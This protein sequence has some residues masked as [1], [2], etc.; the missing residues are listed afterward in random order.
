MIDSQGQIWVYFLDIPLVEE[1][2]TVSDYFPV[3]IGFGVICQNSLKKMY[4]DFPPHICWTIVDDKEGDGSLRKNLGPWPMNIHH[5]NFKIW[6]RRPVSVKGGRSQYK[7]LGLLV[8]KGCGSAFG[9]QW[10]LL[11]VYPY[12]GPPK[13]FSPGLGCSLSSYRKF[14]ILCRPER[15]KV[16]RLSHAY[17]APCSNLPH[18]LCLSFLSGEHRREC[19]EAGGSVILEALS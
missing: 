6:R 17:T 3:S 10:G 18:Q 1:N 12:W 16:E 2:L 19:G 13:Y 15:L 9:I 7:L 8:W 11:L 14:S 4:F 5:K